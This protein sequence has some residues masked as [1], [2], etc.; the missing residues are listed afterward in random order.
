MCKDNSL[1]FLNGIGYNVVRLPRVGIDPLLV[2]GGGKKNLTI[3]G[4]LS[5]IVL[6]ASVPLP[7]ITT[8]QPAANING[9][10]SNQIDIDV[11]LKFLE[12]ILSAMGAG[13]AKLKVAYK[14]VNKI[15]FQFE[16]VLVDSVLPFSMA[17]YL[18]GAKPDMTHSMVDNFD[19]EGEAFL[20][21]ETIKSN[22]LGTTAYDNHG[23]KVDLDIDAIQNII[24]GAANV[25][26][27]KDETLKLSYRGTQSLRFGFKAS[28]M[29][30]QVNH[31][32][33]KF[34]LNPIGGEIGPLRALS[35]DLD[36]PDVL[37][38]VLIGQ[39]TLLKLSHA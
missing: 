25:S 16:N 21:M 39:N 15:E 20:I 38:T 9:L 31:G 17:K 13:N 32:V 28:P 3:L 11:G 33:P 6:S 14:K 27:T 2:L 5:D 30:A 35:P 8:D 18:Q 19:E 36:D 37:T 34:R 24:G 10:K 29:W 22:A 4:P 12:T 23:V 7:T 26:V 1:T